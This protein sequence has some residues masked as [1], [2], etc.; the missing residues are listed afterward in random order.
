MTT[1]TAPSVIDKNLDTAC[2]TVAGE[3][4]RTGGEA[5]LLLAFNGAV[6]AGLGSVADKDCRL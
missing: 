5:S 3:I 2:A 4:E 1:F 6:L